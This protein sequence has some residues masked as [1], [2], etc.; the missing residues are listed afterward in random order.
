MSG[1][2]QSLPQLGGETLLTDSGL[3]TDLIF[4]H[5]W[6]LP[7]FASFVLLDQAQGVAAFREY[8][9][10]HAAVARDAGVGF[11]FEA[12]TW[13]ASVDWASQLGYSEASLADV[14]RRAIELMVELRDELAEA[15]LGRS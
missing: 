15:R 5:G 3:E 10:E 6:E 4:H 12:V 8:Y 14:N 11:L 9:L 1:Y 13:R 7:L 2:R